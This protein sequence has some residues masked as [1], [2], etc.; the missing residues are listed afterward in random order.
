MYI[1]NVVLHQRVFKYYSCSEGEFEVLQIAW[2]LSSLSPYPSQMN[3]SFVHKRSGHTVVHTQ[4]G[5][6]LYKGKENS[7]QS[8]GTGM[9]SLTTQVSQHDEDELVKRKTNL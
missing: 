7:F 1:L 6:S 8:S 5:G 4:S 3:V 9:L 2:F